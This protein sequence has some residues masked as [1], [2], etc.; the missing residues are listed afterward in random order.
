M[1]Y[2]PFYV[3]K[4]DDEDD[5]DEE[6]SVHHHYHHG[7]H[8]HMAG[9]H[10][11][12]YAREHGSIMAAIEARMENP[13]HTWA[14]HHGKAGGMMSIVEMEYMELMDAK[15]SGSKHSIEKELA[16]LAAACMCALKK[17]KDM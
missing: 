3:I 12:S 14:A 7:H 1:H 6:V 4:R 2:K 5:E 17:M 15:S 16:D 11:D 10:H 8:P 9:Y 13:P